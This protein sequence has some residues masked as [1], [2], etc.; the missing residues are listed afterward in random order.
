M[1]RPSS[2][3]AFIIN[4]LEG[5]GAERVMCKLL[6]IMQADFSRSGVRVHLIIL[7]ELPEQQQV[8]PYVNKITLDSRGSLY[9]GYDALKTVLAEIRPAICVSFLT[10]ANMLNI[11]LARK[12]VHQAVISER[13]NTSRHFSG[14]LKDI[15]SK[16]LVR[17]SYPFAD[18]VIAVSD[19]V[20]ADLIRNYGV[21]AGRIQTVY[22]PYDITEMSAQAAEAVTDLPRQPYIIGTGRLVRNKNFNLLLQA[23]A[24]SSIKHD[25]VI[26]GQGE[27]RS[28]LISRAQSLGLG[29]RLHLPGYRANPYPFIK[30]ADFFVSTSNAE[31]FPNAI[32]EAMC[33]GK[34]VVATNC[35]S[36]PAEILTGE[37]PYSVKGF[38]AEAYGCIC[39]VNNVKAVA[40]ALNFM[41]ADTNKKK[42][43]EKSQQ[44]AA[45]F[46]N[47]A[48][49]QR[50]RAVLG[51]NI[52]QLE[53]K[54]VS[55]Y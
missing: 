38:R 33:L 22:N 2:D 17:V 54:N 37:Y 27:E 12:S 10:R 8:P 53:L 47:A 25:I 20:R 51:L 42:Y 43:A 18:L 35:E 14:G 39:E 15:I 21:R 50:I 7:D 30:H 11:S 13:V 45:M 36:G 4:S 1:A 40:N 29:E 6:T 41:S 44:R 52:T 32:A 5:G 55:G 19:G 16:A 28:A 46:S 26:L 49:R 9:K 31:G 23:V 48:F 34:P 24:A 3:I